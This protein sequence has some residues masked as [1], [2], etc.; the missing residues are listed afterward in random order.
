MTTPKNIHAARRALDE[1]R[2]ALLRAARFYGR[3][4]SIRAEHDG[5]A[6]YIAKKKRERAR[7]GLR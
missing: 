6:A 7:R 3:E 1:A 2:A 5:S 4:P